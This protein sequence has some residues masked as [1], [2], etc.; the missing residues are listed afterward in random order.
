MKIMRII[1]LSFVFMLSSFSPAFP[2][3]ETLTITTYYPAPFGVYRTLRVENNGEQ[4]IIGNDPNTPGIE[5]RDGDAGTN[6]P[7]ID[8]SD[9]PFG[10]EDYDMRIIL[11]GAD[12]LLIDGGDLAA[13]R[14]VDVDRDLGVGGYINVHDADI[15]WPYVHEDGDVW[16]S[17]DLVFTNPDGYIYFKK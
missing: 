4:I 6:T 17:Q 3:A 12:E 9:E 7:Y 15:G 8:F 10:G 16:L 5:L 11:N 14:D 1:F 2:Q 13:G